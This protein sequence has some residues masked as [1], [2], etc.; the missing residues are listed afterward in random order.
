MRLCGVVFSGVLG[1][2]VAANEIASSTTAAVPRVARLDI[3][4]R[5]GEQLL[6]SEGLTRGSS[7]GQQLVHNRTAQAYFATLNIGTPPQSNDLLVDTG[8]AELWVLEQGADICQG[9]GTC[10]DTFD[11][12]LSSSLELVQEDGFE[13]V[14]INNDKARGDVIQDVI[15]VGAAGSN[16]IVIDDLQ[17]GLVRESRVDTGILGIGY[18]TSGVGN[19]RNIIGELKS[20]GHIAAKA[21]SL[22]LDD[23]SSDTGSLLLGGID[24]TKFIGSLQ[25]I[26]VLPTQADTYTHFLV[27]L[28]S[29]VAN[30]SATS[31]STQDLYSN[32]NDSSSSSSSSLRV[33]LDS[34][35]TISYLPNELVRSIWKYFGVRDDRNNTGVGLV[36][37]ALATTSVGLTVDFRFSSPPRS[38]GPVI[39][40][41]FREF[42]VDN[43]NN[44][45]NNNITLPPDL[46]FENACSFG[47]LDSNNS[48]PILGQNFLRSA[49]VVHDLD[50]HRIGL[51]QAN[52]NV[53]STAAAPSPGGGG[54]ADSI[55]EITGQGIPISVMGVA[56][57]GA[58][59]DDDDAAPGGGGGG[60]PTTPAGAGNP[61]QPTGN[62]SAGLLYARG[63]SS[64]SWWMVSLVLVVSLW[65]SRAG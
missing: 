6:S 45:N 41:P 24:R 62:T 63:S 65:C 37:C 34:G 33:V 47:L 59:L 46:G 21:Y 40:V 50:H 10:S 28:D 49:Y 4:R 17:F 38:A 19:H 8:S 12:I 29:I 18:P 32:Q 64:R 13:V 61:S 9:P 15:R 23:Y 53:S 44:K 51:A 7:F 26:D 39:K 22:Y 57:Q 25:T 48:L 54:E 30:F 35:T 58:T 5:P 27:G 1:C 3:R 56:F 55:V 16:A 14:Y 11:P 60:T 36:D 20:G 52:L 2:V 42:I 43:I 31:G